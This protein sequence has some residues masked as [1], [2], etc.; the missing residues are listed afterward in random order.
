MAVLS[1]LLGKAL[2]VR[3]MDER[4]QI[5]A[6]ASYPTRAGVAIDEEGALRV[7]AA[8]I[9]TTLIADEIASLAARIVARDD[10][11]RTPLR[12]PE[13]QPLWGRP[14]TDQTQVEWRSATVLSLLLWG[15]SYVALIWDP[16]TGALVQMVTLH[17]ASCDVRR[18]ADGGI[19][20]VHHGVD[21]EVVLSV[22][23]GRRPDVMV[24]R[25]YDIPGRLVPPS[26]V[27]LAAETLGLAVAYD[28]IAAHLAGRGLA[29]SAVL[30]VDEP[31]PPEVAR[32]LSERLQQLH[33]GPER[34]G[35]VAVIGGRGVRLE[36]LT[37]APA[38]VQLVAQSERVFSVVM[39]LWRVPPTVAG[40]VDKPSTWGTGV[41]EFSRGLE[42]FTLRPVA[43]R[44]EQ[45]IEDYV[46]R[47]VDERLQYRL[48]FDALLSASPKERAEVEQIRLMAGMT[49]VE[50]VLAL[51]DEPPLGDDE[52]VLLPLNVQTMA[53]REAAARLRSAE[54]YARLI[55]AGIERE[56]AA[57]LA[58]IDL[59][60]ARSQTAA[61]TG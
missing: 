51:E 20:V 52:R 47:W 35:R 23:P 36:R 19:D 16:D 38:D 13:L 43:R 49:S 26:P 14:N 10:V 7:A 46:L 8:W 29:P 24:V 48:R 28:R 5:G 15:V 11:R 9:A 3:L 25:L 22:P 18:R 45:A 60:G 42:R 2:R 50:R 17:P 59:P 40:M 53:E 21:G 61:D 34:A 30:T 54:V 57:A 44:L 55:Q 1:Q 6:L 31:I 39:A 58:G 12:P 27:Q 32:E 37:W 4:S 41:A 56:E 33:G